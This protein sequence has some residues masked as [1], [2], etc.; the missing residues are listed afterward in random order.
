MQTIVAADEEPMR[1]MRHRWSIC[2]LLLIITT[3]NYM[4]RQLIGIL[5]PLLQGTLGW[6][7]IDYGNIVLAFQTAYAIGL[8]LAGRLLDR[9]GTRR[10]FSFAV[11]V[12]SLAAAAHALTRGV[13]G[14]ALARFGLG[15]GE[16]AHFPAAIKTVAEWFPRSERALATGVF[17]A[18]ATLGALI[19][20]L[21]VP[22]AIAAFGWRATFV[23]TGSLGFVW[24]AL[25]LGLHA[26]LRVRDRAL[27]EAE[28]DPD[29]APRAPAWREVLPQ[30]VAW[31]FACAKFLTD[32][33]WWLYLFWLPDFFS[34]QFHLDLQRLSLPTAAVYLAAGVGSIFGGALSSWLIRR[35]VAVGRAR[36]LAMLLCA[37]AVTPVWFA[38]FVTRT[39]LA[40]A[41]IGLA[42]AA[43][44]G[45]SANLLT[46]V[47]D[48]FPQRMVSSVT[49]FGSMFGAV[50]GMLIAWGVAHLLQVSGSYVPVFAIAGG[51]Y[52]TALLAFRLLAPDLS[53]LRP[54]AGN[55]TAK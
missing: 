17:N 25:W 37:L 36:T 19:T 30:R 15:L 12:W 50:G 4:D 27:T 22:Y 11:A 28:V 29:A 13:A 48:V 49:G 43:H 53:P 39:W 9:L 26:R 3:I 41:M 47:S 34:R 8:V 54:G 40:V 18:G 24:I 45:W 23:L 51:A 6:S 1:G 55:Q 44:Q 42:A 5:K 2:A 33:I 7:E 32:P 16:S 46:V 21:M 52:L 14:F 38:P 35:G 31:A 20:P 10:G